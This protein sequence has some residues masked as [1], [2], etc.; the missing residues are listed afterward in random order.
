ML[1]LLRSDAKLSNPGSTASRADIGRLLSV[2]AVMTPEKARRRVVCKGNLTIPAASDKSAISAEGDSSEAPP[3]E[4]KDDLFAG[5]QAPLNRLFQHTTED[6]T[7]VLLE[8]TPLVD[9]HN[10]RQ[11]SIVDS[12]GKH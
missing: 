7:R 10:S 1:H 2:F 6:A 4:E 8:L 5:I 3:V 9:Q 11:G 12:A